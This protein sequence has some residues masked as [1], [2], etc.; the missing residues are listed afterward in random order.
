MDLRLF[1]PWGVVKKATRNVCLHMFKWRSVVTSRVWTEITKSY[2]DCVYHFKEV[3]HWFPEEPCHFTFVWGWPRGFIFS[4]SSLAFV[5]TFLLP[6]SGQAWK[7]VSLWFWC[8]FLSQLIVLSIFSCVLWPF[9]LQKSQFKSSTRFD[10]K[11]KGNKN[12]IEQVELYQTKN[13]LYFDVYLFLTTVN[14]FD[15]LWCH[16]NFSLFLMLH[17]TSERAHFFDDFNLN[18]LLALH[19]F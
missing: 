18:L 12:K 1:L 17:R 8:A 2:G 4:V 15:P 5:M 10:T 13:Q 3:W 16:I 14:C 19:I 11:R 9:P 7:G 6:V